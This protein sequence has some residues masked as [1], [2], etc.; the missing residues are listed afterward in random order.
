M[1]QLPNEILLEILNFTYKCKKEKNYILDKNFLKI[2]NKKCKKCKFV[3]LL[4]KKL[5]YNCERDKIIK[6][7][8]IINNLLPS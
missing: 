3:Y 1:N 6:A 7:R 2:H 4:H 5:C 8:L